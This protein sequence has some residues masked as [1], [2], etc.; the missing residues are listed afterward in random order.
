MRLLYV[1]DL[2]LEGSSLVP[3]RGRGGGGCTLKTLLG[4]PFDVV[5]VVRKVGC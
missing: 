1:D 5:S 4:S 3:P 2:A